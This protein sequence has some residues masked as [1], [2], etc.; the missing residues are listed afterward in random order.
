MAAGSAGQDGTLDPQASGPPAR[1]ATMRDVAALAG[2]SI[3][4]VSRVV[5]GSPDVSAELQQRV[6]RA[7]AQ[8]SFHPNLAASSLRRSDGKTRQVALLLEDVANPFSATLHRAIEDVAGPRGTLVFAG[9]LDED[10]QRELELV[11]ASVQ[12]RMDG[13]IIVPAS[14]DHGYLHREMHTGTPVVFVDR[15]PRGL[16]ADAVLCDNVDGAYQATAHLAAQGHRD[17]AFLG[18]EWRIHTVV[19]RLEGY[20]RALADHGLPRRE[21]FVV[22]DLSDST[23]A[24]RAAREL[25]RLP[26]PPTALFTGQNLVTMGAI[27]TLQDL[28]LHKRVAVVGF[29]DFPTADLLDPRVTVVA[30]DVSRIGTLAIRRLFDRIAGDTSPVR[31]ER[32]PPRLIVRGSGELPPDGGRRGER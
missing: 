20:E 14:P 17:I 32:V 28:G 29:D 21:E 11:R 2:V 18:D 4:T 16:A 23:A 27:E 6:W 8:L 24:A 3:K 1:R 7:S 19:E 31:E 15:P 10:A 22:G 5:N 9:S 30:Q 12:H 13:I 26:D 25:M